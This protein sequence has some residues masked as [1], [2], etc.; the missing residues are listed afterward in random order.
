MS[1]VK[2]FVFANSR[3]FET[4]SVLTDYWLSFKTKAAATDTI[5]KIMEQSYSDFYE[6]K[7][8]LG[9][10]LHFAEAFARN[11]HENLIKNLGCCKFSI[12]S[13]DLV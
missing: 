13:W 8:T 5:S 12:A 9:V 1:T 2:Y 4:N 3:F 11:N 10:I 7:I 6:S